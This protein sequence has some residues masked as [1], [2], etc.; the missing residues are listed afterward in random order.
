MTVCAHFWTFRNYPTLATCGR[1]RERLVGMRDNVK[2][3]VERSDLVL[4]DSASIET[5]EW[6]E[7][8][9][10]S[11][12]R[13]A[14]DDEAIALV[15]LLSRSDE[16]SCF[17]LKHAVLHFIETAPGWPIWSTLND[18]SGEWPA[19][20]RLRLRNAGYVSP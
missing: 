9:I 20:L 6:A 16:S 12:E 4:S 5:V 8:L 7:K 2:Q 11:F 17:G 13:P 1:L 15:N 19:S 14:Q 10:E 18:A 3:L